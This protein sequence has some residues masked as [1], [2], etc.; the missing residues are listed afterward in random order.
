MAYPWEWQNKHRDSYNEKADPSPDQ[1]NL[2][3]SF[4]WSHKLSEKTGIPY[5]NLAQVGNSNDI[6]INRVMSVM[7]RNNLINSLVVLGLTQPF[8]HNIPSKN[9]VEVPVV[10]KPT[11]EVYRMDDVKND[12][13]EEDVDQYNKLWYKVA[14]DEKQMA[15]DMGLKIKMFSEYLKSRWSKL[16]VIDNLFNL[17]LGKVRDLRDKEYFLNFDNTVKFNWP[18]HI[19]KYDPEYSLEHHPNAEDHQKLADLIYKRYIVDKDNKDAI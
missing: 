10:I 11:S 2:A 13:T 16:I 1:Q 6:A 5:L 17:S 14:Y 12:V 19:Q 4:S 15:H 9:G 7:E 3:F 8:R 18:K